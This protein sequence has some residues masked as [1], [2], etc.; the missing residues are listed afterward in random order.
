[1]TGEKALVWDVPRAEIPAPEW[2]ARL[3]ESV[4]G[5]RLD[6][7]GVTEVVPTAEYFALQGEIAALDGDGFYERIAKWFVE[8]RSTRK[9]S[10]FSQ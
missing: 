2:F 8:D 7:D 9:R 6:A 1:M 5:M 4:V 3:A 10:P